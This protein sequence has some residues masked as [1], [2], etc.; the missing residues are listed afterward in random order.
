MA[1]DH[2][3]M[4]AAVAYALLAL[5]WKS[6]CSSSTAAGLARQSLRLAPEGGL[7][8]EKKEPAVDF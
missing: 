1:A 7:L 5:G 6:L 3:R 8:H 4:A 2:E